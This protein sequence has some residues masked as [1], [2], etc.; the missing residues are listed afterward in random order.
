MTDP[1]PALA[2]PNLLYRYADAMDAGDFDGAAKLFRH[3]H[4]SANGRTIRDSNDIVALWREW[5][6]FHADGTPGTRH[7][8]TNP[9]IELD[10]TGQTARCKSQWT[11]LQATQELPL[12]VIATG[13]YDDRFALIDNEWNFTERKYSALELVGDTSHHLRKQPIEENR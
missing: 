4:V 8:V 2:I 6:R 7:L 10:D 1:D 13:R 3:G 11:I 5:V 12:Q 9:I